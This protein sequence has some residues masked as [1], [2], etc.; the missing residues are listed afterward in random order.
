ML[1]LFERVHETTYSLQH[2][3]D[4]GHACICHF[5]ALVS[6]R[7][8]PCR[9][10][11]YNWNKKDQ[12]SNSDQS[13]RSHDYQQTNGYQN[14]GKRQGPDQMPLLRDL[15]RNKSYVGVSEYEG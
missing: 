7:Q 11:L 5:D 10:S 12:H 1:I 3:A 4:N 6:N 9:N 15:D 2:A 8:H 14:D 13:G